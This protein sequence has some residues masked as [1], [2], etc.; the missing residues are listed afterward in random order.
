MVC[1]PSPTPT[2]AGEQTGAD[3]S[4][5]GKTWASPLVLGFRISGPCLSLVH[6]TLL[7][8]FATAPVICGGPFH[9]TSLISKSM[10]GA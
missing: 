7:L 9:F 10:E 3:E 2:S 1:C 8:T 6:L 5:R 4:P